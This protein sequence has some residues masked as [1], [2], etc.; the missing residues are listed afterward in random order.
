[1]QESDRVLVLALCALSGLSLGLHV[2]QFRQL[3]RL[4][5]NVVTNR[6]CVEVDDALMRTDSDVSH[7]ASDWWD[8]QRESD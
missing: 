1:M 6:R 5:E 7:T 2:K 3:H 4:Q 8:F